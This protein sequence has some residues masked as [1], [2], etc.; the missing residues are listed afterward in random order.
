MS[1]NTL[2][3]NPP[4]QSKPW[5]NLYVDTLTAYKDIKS[6]NLDVND[7]TFENGKGEPGQIMRKTPTGIEWANLPGAKIDPGLPG[8]FL[9][10]DT[11]TGEVEWEDFTLESVPKGAPHQVLTTSASGDSIEWADPP[12]GGLTPGDPYQILATNSLG[13]AVEWINNDPNVVPGN[14][15]QY[16]KTNSSYE[17]EWSDPSLSAISPG[18]P[19]Q[20]LATN[21]LG[22]EAEWIDKEPEIEPGQ[23]GQFFKTNESGNLQWEDLSL[24]YIPAG[25]ENQILK[26]GSSGLPEWSNIINPGSVYIEDELNI[27]GNIVI[28]G[29]SGTT[30]QYI[31]KTGATTQAWSKIQANDIS[32]GTSNQV[33]TTNAAGNGTTWTSS[34]TVTGVS[35]TTVN[36]IGNLLLTSTSGTTGQYI[37]KTGSNTQAWSK[38]QVGDITPGA[39]NQVL[40]TTEAGPMW[41]PFLN[42]ETISINGGSNLTYYKHLPDITTTW[43]HNSNDV[44]PLTIKMSRIGRVVTVS[45]TGVST[46]I[47]SPDDK[48]TSATML[49]AEIRPNLPFD[50]IIV[51]YDG[52]TLDPVNLIVSIGGNGAIIIKDYSETGDWSGKTF[53]KINLTWHLD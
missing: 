23:P 16:L 2:L 47:P 31:R 34:L 20:I 21:S 10:T 50:Q 14:P 13:N 9:K 33:L 53:L 15:G 42:V 27:T 18:L 48:L 30:G 24:Q 29:N 49:P 43:Q 52:T 41:S 46:A 39:V 4:S 40:V 12:S 1:I 44:S 11:D 45:L 7:F 5:C 17:F 3:E 35:A 6:K 22:T 36:V 38:I 32:S 37:R 25:T 19:Y 8:Q 26:T 51:G 28:N